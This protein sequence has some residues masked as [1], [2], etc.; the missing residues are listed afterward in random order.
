MNWSA[1]R[2]LDA[3]AS[4]ALLVDADRV[5]SNTEKMIAMVG[6]VEKVGRLR[7]HVKTHKMSE[8]VRLQIAAGIDKFKAATISEANMVAAAGGKSV[9]L[10]YQ[11]VGP[12]IGRLAQSIKTYPATTFSAV[13]D[14]ETVVESIAAQIGIAD[15]AIGNADH[16][17]G[18]ADHPIT[19]LIDVDCGMHR[20][21]I[22]L[23][24]AMD[25]LRA[26][27]ES[28]RGVR[29]G[30]LHV[31]DGHLHQPALKERR[32]AA[33]EIIAALRDYQDRTPSPMIVGGGSPTFA[34]WAAET[35]WECSPGT[36]VFWDAGY[37]NAYPDLKFERAVALL[38]RV[39]SK[40]G[41]NRVCLD[42]GYKA[43]ASEMPLER[44]VE[45]PE[46]DDVRLLGHSEEHL[47]IETSRAQQLVIGQPLLAFPCHICPTVALHAR[48]TIVRGDR[49][50]GES[51]DVTARDR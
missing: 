14:D 6:G 7:P 32:S 47:V 50:T 28:T 33:A 42:L 21:G 29:F 36:P 43:V 49:A 44:R 1:V 37:G 38:T 51:W 45:F 25:R 16:A 23:G 10:A 39:I 12:N 3:I 15:H 40:P 11:P 31:Y 9:L 4:P 13:V 18:N 26:R 17:I 48:A 46:L 35:D 24:A 20:T 22:P 8:V 27:I 41:E 34:I 30:G 19:L 2:N 5:A